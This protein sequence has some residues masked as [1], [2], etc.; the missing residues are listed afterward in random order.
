MLANLKEK[1]VG[2]S[3]LWNDEFQ[4]I[5]CHLWLH[6]GHRM[7]QSALMGAPD[8]AHWH[9]SF[10]CMQDLYK[11]QKIHKERMEGAGE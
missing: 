2:D 10:E 4:N 9:G 8:Y 1:G 5:F 6:E 7:R 3:N 11:L